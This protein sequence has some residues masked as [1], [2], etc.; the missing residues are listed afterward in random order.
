MIHDMGDISLLPEELR[1]REEEERRGAHEAGRAAPLL[2]VPKNGNGNGTL[3]QAQGD[4]MN[5]RSD[6]PKEISKP[7]A[8]AY[9]TPE[10]ESNGGVWKKFGIS[11]IPGVA[12]GPTKPA[13]K[14]SGPRPIAL[15]WII[16]AVLIVA[17]GFVGVTVAAFRRNTE[18]ATIH[19]ALETARTEL[20]RV[21]KTSSDE[22]IASLRL[23]A[24]A[25]L[26]A[27]HPRPTEFF[28]ALESETLSQVRFSSVTYGEKSIGLAAVASRVEDL[29]DQADIFAQSGRYAS[30]TL[31][32]LARSRLT[33]GSALVKA[34]FTLTPL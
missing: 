27:K 20:A 14:P 15:Y 18:L 3:R 9:H 21:Q 7:A 28:R 23:E 30:V 24:A 19:Q 34:T 25:G 33:D 4:K 17:L 1:K 32:P 22:R 5:A 10:K 13:T 31:G 11:L 8:P 29:A 2:H 26:F 6:K 12:A 16:G